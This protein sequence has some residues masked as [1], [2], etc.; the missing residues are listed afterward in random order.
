[1]MRGKRTTLGDIDDEVK[2]IMCVTLTT[3]VKARW[4]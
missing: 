3:V 1:M 4:E 2:P